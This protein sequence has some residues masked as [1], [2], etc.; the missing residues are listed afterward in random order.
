MVCFNKL[1]AGF[2]GVKKNP[3]IEL[4][5]DFIKKIAQIFVFLKD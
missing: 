5:L 2:D 4:A 1:D 3:I